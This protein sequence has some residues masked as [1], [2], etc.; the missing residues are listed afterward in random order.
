MLLFETH[1]SNK[2]NIPT[3]LKGKTNFMKQIFTQLQSL[4]AKAT[5]NKNIMQHLKLLLVAMMATVMVA[6]GQT[7]STF[8]TAPNGLYFNGIAFDASGNLFVTSGGG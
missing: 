5:P 3:S 1:I 4:S 7:V 8:A 6:K 2:N